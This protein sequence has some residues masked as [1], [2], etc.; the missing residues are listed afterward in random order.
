MWEEAWE[1]EK[2]HGVKGTGS[3]SEGS[4][5]M[6]KT[7]IIDSRRMG[8]RGNRA[9]LWQGHGAVT[10]ELCHCAVASTVGGHTLHIKSQASPSP[11][12]NHATL[13]SYKTDQ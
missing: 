11:C 6:R 13:G 7:S 5:D 1:F 8:V 12:T 9:L 2:V 10:K 3:T 4:E